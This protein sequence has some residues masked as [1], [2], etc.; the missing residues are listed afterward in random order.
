M[1]DHSIIGVLDAIAVY[2]V[3]YSCAN[4][5]AIEVAC[6]AYK[7][8]SNDGDAIYCDWISNDWC[9]TDFKYILTKVGVVLDF[10]GIDVTCEIE[11]DEHD[12]TLLLGTINRCTNDSLETDPESE[13]ECE[14]ECEETDPVA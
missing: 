9:Y 7:T 11:H 2:N 10:M 13:S 8:F 4:K 1:A 14:S 6:R 3:G 5:I 12:D